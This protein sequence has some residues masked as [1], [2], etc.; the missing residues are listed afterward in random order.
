[1]W[2]IYKYTHVPCL[3]SLPPTLPHP[4][5]LGHY[6]ALGW[7]SCIIQQLPTSYFPYSNV[8]FLCYSLSSSYAF[9]PPLYPQFSL[10]L[11]LYSCPVNRLIATIFLDSIYMHCAKSPPLCMTLFNPM[12]HSPPGSYVHGDSPGKNTGVG[13]HALL[14][15]IFPM[16]GL[17]LCLLCL[18]HWQAGSLLPA[19]PGKAIY[20][21]LYNICFSLSDLFNSI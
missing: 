13:C 7:A 18:L 9:L 16:Q 5:S 3:P 12:D 6:R 2:I 10:C 15:E 1:M 11:N 20:A 14:Q 21:L 8:M 17:N 4:I 19:P